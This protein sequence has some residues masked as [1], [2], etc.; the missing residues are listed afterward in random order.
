MDQVSEKNSVLSERVIGVA[1]SREEWIDRLN[2]ANDVK[3][4]VGLLHYGLDLDMDGDI[5]R[6][7]IICIYFDY[8]YGYNNSM[9]FSG[10]DSDP[11]A[12][13]IIDLGFET[14]S[15]V[16]KDFLKQ[17]VSAK[18]F[19]TLCKK[20]L[21][22]RSRDSGEKPTWWD[23]VIYNQ[24][25]FEKILWFFEYSGNIPFRSS[26]PIRHEESTAI[27]FLLKLSKAAW[28]AI[29][30]SKKIS[31]SLIENRDHFIKILWSLDELD[32]LVEHWKSLSKEDFSTLKRLAENLKDYRGPVSLTDAF[33]EGNNMATCY[34]LIA[35][36]AELSNWSFPTRQEIIEKYE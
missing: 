35:K 16:N 17:Y 24:K 31:T 8:A 26:K 19:D 23:D 21:K 32:F 7:D 28:I 14:R 20:F 4:L 5:S 6:S 15:S 30:P 34:Q 12:M 11:F 9:S 2:K 33:I 22:N 10:K 29:A 18:A 36:K 3:T 27:E 13:R 1:P 25:I